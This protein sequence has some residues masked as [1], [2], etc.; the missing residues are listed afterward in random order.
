M[1]EMD[2]KQAEATALRT[3]EHEEFMKASKDY[4][5]SA[6]AVTNRRKCQNVGYLL[7]SSDNLTVNRFDQICFTPGQM[8]SFFK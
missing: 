7:Q 4:K 8:L 2:A 5:D 6:E 1:A 3:K